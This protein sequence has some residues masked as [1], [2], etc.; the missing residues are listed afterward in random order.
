GA[1]GVAVLPTLG[2][3][4][5]LFAVF[6]LK[7]G[8]VPF[9]FWV[10]DAYRAAP[11]PVTAVLA[12]VVKK[13][14]VYAVVRL[15]FTVFAAATVPV[16]LPGLAGDSPL[17]YIGPVLFVLAAASVVLGGVGAVGRDDLGGLLAFSSISQVGFIVLPLAVAATVPAVRTLG[18]AAALV[19]AFNHGLAKSMLF[20]AAGT[21]RS[22]VGSTRFAD[23]GG[24]AGRAPVLSAGFLVGALS[25]VGI[26]PLSGFFGKLLVFD[27]AARAFAANAAGA[28][29]AAALALAG[30]VLTIAYYTR[31]WN[32][33]FWGQPSPLVEAGIPRRWTRPGPATTEGA[34]DDDGAPAPDGGRP[35]RRRL[36]VEVGVVAALAVAVVAFGLG[37]EA[38]Y[39]AAQAGAE[40]AVD[41]GGY[42]DAVDPAEV[43]G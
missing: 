15:Y 9:H 3:G 18:V 38:V 7:A 36:A 31:A 32:G 21:V 4:A 11:A 40:A 5:V 22:A 33:A 19:Y 10:P 20:L 23:L 26:P 30:A 25:L 41:T 1:Y 42:V 28:G 6:A 8:L 39:A 27:T 13:V 12:G 34:P 35:S 24:L 29:A 37:F 17:A 16:S 14:G 43:V 2:L